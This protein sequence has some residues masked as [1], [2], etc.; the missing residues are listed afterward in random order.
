MFAI[1]RARLAIFAA[2]LTPAIILA[3]L[4]LPAPSAK[5]APIA[6][7]FHWGVA[8][9]GFQVE[10]SNP[11]SNWLRY[12]EANQDSDDVDPVN[13]AVDFWN[14]YEEDIANAAAMG[15]NTYRIS[16]EW[17]RIEP[18]PGHWDQA[19]LEH[20]DR[21]I[22]TIRDHGMT[23]MITMVH[24]VYP[25]WLVDRGGFLDPEAP[26]LFGRYAELITQRWGDGDTM[27][28]TFN[29]PLVFYGHEVEIGLI[30][31]TDMPAFLDN[32]VAAHKLGYA[33]AHAANPNAMVTTNEAFLPAV[34]GLADRVFMDR[35]ADSLDYVGIDY[36]YGLSADNISAIYAA[37]AEFGRVRPQPDGIYEAIRHF[38]EAF[39]GLPIY[40]VE[41]G[42]PSVNGERADGA[43]RGDFV[44]DTIFWIQRAIA[45]GYPVIGYNHW[46][47]TDNYEWGDY[48][49]RFGLYRVD[50]LNDPTLTRQPTSGVAAYRDLITNGGVPQGYQPVNS[51]AKCSAARIPDS[52]LN[53]PQVDG[54]LAQIRG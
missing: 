19:A 46:S 44:S 45:D 33:A 40:I 10:G 13:D 42:M 50:I 5:G 37:N 51:P 38:S 49:A 22:G 32:V 26:A 7:D 48:S 18:E 31:T 23:P 36:Y 43:T 25:G 20:Y 52:C 39:P 53:P 6:R 34:T 21:I 47:I 11:D 17:A 54:P 35:V 12:V 27:W 29:E 9:S 2:A 14:R 16:V 24:Y 30:D 8:S 15:V 1:S 41:N 3:L 28:V 4:V